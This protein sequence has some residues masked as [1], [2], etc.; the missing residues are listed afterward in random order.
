MEA[1]QLLLLLGDQLFPSVREDFD[2]DRAV[3]WMAED[4]EL[5]THHRYHKHKLV[6]FLSAMR[7]Y[8]DGLREAGLT[9]HYSHLDGTT[10]DQPYLDRLGN[11]LDD[12]PAIDTLLGYRVEDAFF[13]DRLN[14]FCRERD[15]NYA[16][17]PS[18]GFVTTREE[19][20]EYD[21]G[22]KKHHMAR[23]YE[24]QRRRLNV[25]VDEAGDPLHGKWSFDADNRKKLPKKYEVPPQPTYGRTEHTEAVATLVD[26]HFSDHPGKTDNFWLATT[27]RQALH[28][29]DDFLKQRF[30]D[31][32]PYEDAFEPSAPFLLHSVL[33]PYINM[34]LITAAEVTQRATDYARDNDV[35]YPSVEG[36]VRQIIGWREFIRGMY[37]NYAPDM[38]GT[39]FFGHER[40]LTEHWWRGDTGV[41]PVDDCIRRAN[42]YGYLHHIERLMVMGNMLLLSEVHPDEA[43]RW[44]MEFFVD[45]ADWVMVPN[46]Y[47]MSQFADGGLFATKPYICGAN[48]WS[49][50]SS[51]SKKADWA[52]TVDGLYWRFV[53]QKRD[54]LRSNPRLS[55]MVNLY[56]KM[57]DEKKERLSA[58]AEAWL[59]RCTK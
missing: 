8:A 13:A 39:N 23:F 22:A 49:K 36:F 48:Y 25:L 31:F 40:K 35:H 14:D 38:Q 2:L 41:A 16:P 21:S 52:D 53:D 4:Y 43:Y 24:Q 34:G 20:A 17:L 6:L 10:L 57:A 28:Q 55:M 32:G 27:R 30:A 50:M 1:N 3:I 54:F 7:S 19:F 42:E 47:G 33:S 9:V 26:E 5:C 44:F 18:A 12:H 29:V 37:H 59:A 51:Y 11:F 15:L 58:A 45:S 56:D 46:V